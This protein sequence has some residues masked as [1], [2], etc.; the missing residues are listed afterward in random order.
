[1]RSDD[2]PGRASGNMSVVE[3]AFLTAWF[4]GILALAPDV[5]GRDMPLDR[6]GTFGVRGGL[7][8]SG[9]LEG[10]WMAATESSPRLRS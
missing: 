9:A 7:A 6:V 10:A 3:Q 5:V 1:M 4:A 2:V 8:K